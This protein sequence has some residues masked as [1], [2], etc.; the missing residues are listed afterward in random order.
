MKNQNTFNLTRS[1]HNLIDP[2]VCGGREREVSMMPG[3]FDQP[4]CPGEREREK[5]KC[6]AFDSR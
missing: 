1:E 2:I 5:Q 3:G 6:Q 4:P